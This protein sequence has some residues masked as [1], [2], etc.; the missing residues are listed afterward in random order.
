MIRIPV[1]KRE[2]AIVDDEFEW[3]LVLKWDL[4]VDGSRK[5]A[6]TRMT[7]NGIRKSVSMHRLII[8]ETFGLTKEECVDH[9]SG[10]SLD[11]RRENLRKCTRSQNCQNQRKRKNCSSQ[12]KGVYFDKSLIKKQWRAHISSKHIGCYHTEIEA[13]V[14]YDAKAVEQFGEFARLNFPE[15]YK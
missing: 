1:G 11:N 15:H 4:H 8:Q 13:A 12:Y 2:H 5:Y 10:Y 7:V 6:R 9:R 14:A 3:L